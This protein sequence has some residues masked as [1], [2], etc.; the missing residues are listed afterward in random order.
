[1]KALAAMTIPA[2]TLACSA[3]PRPRPEPVLRPT[4][5][6]TERRTGAVKDAPLAPARRFLEP[7]L[8]SSWSFP[9]A[10]TRKEHAQRLAAKLAAQLDSEHDRATTG[11][12]FAFALV[13]DGEVALL[14]ARGIADLEN[15]RL[16]TPD[17]IYRVASV[18]KTVTATA[19]MALRDE[20]KLTLTD[21]VAQ[22]LPELDVVYPHRDDAPI[23]LE[24]ILTHS[25]GLMRSGPYAELARASTEADLALA[26]RMPLTN[27]PGV[28]HRYS[29]F[30]FGLLGL[31]IAREAK[32]PYRDFVRTR[33]LEPLGMTSSG[34]DLSRLPADRLAV[35]Y[36]QSGGVSGFTPVPMTANGA[37]EAAGGLYSSARDMA[38]Y[39][40]FEL[41]AWPPR[42]D[43]D[44]A[45]VKRASVRETQTPRLPFAL[46]FA[47]V[48]GETSRAHARSVALGWEVLKGCY[49]DHLVG[50]DGDL[51]GFH[52]RL[53]FDIDRSVG[54]VLLGNT[55]G[56]DLS[57]V[58]ERLVDT[59]A[60]EDLLAPRRREPAPVLIERAT[61]AV[62]NIGPSWTAADHDATFSE[63]LRTPFPLA[64]ATAL[65]ERVAKE[66]GTCAYA[67]P[68]VVTD[69]LDAELV[70][71]CERG[72][73]RASVRGTGNPL[74]LYGFKLDVMKPPTDAQVAV[75]RSLVQRMASRNDAALAKAL[76]TKA[77]DAPAKL[78]LT[79]GTEA[80]TCRVGGG[81]VSPWTRAATFRLSCTKTDATLR[82]Q[83]R[84]SGVLD[85]L[86]IETPPRRCL[87]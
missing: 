33:L 46:G 5:V 72:L 64:S 63:T 71:Q 30:G 11:A 52:A 28:S 79:A 59:I 20:G 80:G 40:R 27:D 60:A 21:S 23:R 76:R 78:L 35:G 47:E 13:V 37:G 67:R 6:P 58:A 68:E 18:T 32:M 56:A 66:V 15:K 3:S 77:V 53:R 75:V 39:L 17:T 8:A 19:L 1:M 26:M 54:F 25:A 9:D 29:N 61:F 34:Y 51:E 31:V 87:R 44:D 83:E 57:G 74:R 42:D 38:A 49:F 62:K 86:G 69:A 41:M 12:G 50:H 82:L 70:F 55:D 4:A 10:S 7:E 48:S 16:A 24:Q 36:R 84:A 73:L 65:G 2:I 43:A 85:I 22:H 45:P 81:E 14:H